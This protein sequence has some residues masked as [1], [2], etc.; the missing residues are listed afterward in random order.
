MSHLWA[1]IYTQPL[2]PWRGHFNPFKTSATPAYRNAA[3]QE[4]PSAARHARPFQRGFC[5]PL[6]AA[7]NRAGFYNKTF[8][9]PSPSAPRLVA[10]LPNPPP[11]PLEHKTFVF[12]YAS[13]YNFKIAVYSVVRKHYLKITINRGGR[14][15]SNFL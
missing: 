1:G 2:P 14:R 6:V 3:K 4:P 15:K 12:L 7:S 13:S 8:S 9:T 10:T 5:F 11:R